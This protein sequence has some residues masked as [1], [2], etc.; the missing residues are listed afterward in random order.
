MDRAKKRYEPGFPTHS[1]VSSAPN[2]TRM[3]WPGDA[4]KPKERGN[5]VGKNQILKSLL[6]P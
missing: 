6:E 3:P 4:E 1:L 5:I 2:T